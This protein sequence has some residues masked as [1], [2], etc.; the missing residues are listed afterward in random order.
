MALYFE[1]KEFLDMPTYN[2]YFYLE[3]DTSSPAGEV[4]VGT[5]TVSVSEQEI[6]LQQT[7][8]NMIGSY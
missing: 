7:S 6:N 3:G 1:T 4:V 5:P 2:E 8:T